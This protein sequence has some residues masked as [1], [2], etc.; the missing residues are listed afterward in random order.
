MSKSANWKARLKATQRRRKKRGTAEPIANSP[1]P[2]TVASESVDVAALLIEAA[3]RAADRHRSVRDAAIYAALK[4][5]ANGA[6]ASHESTAQVLEMMNQTLRGNG[7][8]EADSRRAAKE[9]C[10]VARGNLK[11]DQPRQLIQYF[12]LISD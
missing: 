2:A 11:P 6:D 5:L 10:D 8:D 9:L 4:C 12:S 7:V 1:A 3:L